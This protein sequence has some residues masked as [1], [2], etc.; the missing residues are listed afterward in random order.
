MVDN[1]IDFHQSSQASTL[2]I[3]Q[4]ISDDLC[5]NILNTLTQTIKP[6]NYYS[7]DSNPLDN[8]KNDTLILMHIN[9]RSLQKN[10]DLLTEF[11]DFLKLQPNILC[12][13]ERIK[14]QP[15]LNISNPGYSFVHVGATS[16]AGSVATYISNKLEYHFSP[17]Q[18]SLNNSE[19]LWLKIKE[20]KSN[21]KYILGVV[22]RY[23]HQSGLNIFLDDFSACLSNLTSSKKP[24]HILRDLNINISRNNRSAVA[25]EFSFQSSVPHTRMKE[26]HK[27]LSSSIY[28][29]PGRR[30]V[31]LGPFVPFRWICRL[32]IRIPG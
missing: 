23:P 16:N 2:N 21:S 11:L 30:Y 5:D 29:N 14:T 6:C 25:C 20:R 1:L 19:C 28:F 3:S 31:F 9:I 32:E 7:L 4:Q 8:S 24:F 18:H 13:T 27:I 26:I 10:F 15:L 12:L 17:D 22:Y